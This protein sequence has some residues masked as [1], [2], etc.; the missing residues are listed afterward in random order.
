MLVTWVRPCGFPADYF[1]VWK[2]GENYDEPIF[3]IDQWAAENFSDGPN[4][5]PGYW[6]LERFDLDIDQDGIP[7][8]FVTSPRLHGTGGGPHLI[9]QKRGHAYYYSGQLPGR[10]PTMRVLSPGEDGL[11]RIMTFWNNGGGS[12]TASVWTWDGRGFTQEST[13]EIRSGDS[14]TDEGRRRFEE[15]F[16]DGST[17]RSN[18]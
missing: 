15:L 10:K 16:G 5:E 2:L 1:H 4:G 8:M 6:K 17:G 18:R 9:F 7:E 11:P 12:G 14:V 13:E 3:D